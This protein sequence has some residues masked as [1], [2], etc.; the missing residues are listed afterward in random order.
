MSNGTEKQSHAAAAAEA[1][2]QRPPAVSAEMQKVFSRFD[3]DGDGRISPSELAAVSRAISPP[4]SSSHGGREVAAMMD[5]LD[6]DRDGYVDLGEFAAFHAR[7]GRGDDGELEA[8]LRAAFDVYDV[9]GDGRITAAELGK[10][11]AQ[12]GEGCGAEECERMIAS[13]DVDGDGCV[14]FE[15]FKKMMAP[16]GSAAAAPGGDVPDK[17]KK[18]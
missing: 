12:I 15:E 13:V 2:K 14:G 16:Q 18:E 8:E 7:A 4:P 1:Q 5:E 6:A 17:A 3:A 10:V 11:L 9:N